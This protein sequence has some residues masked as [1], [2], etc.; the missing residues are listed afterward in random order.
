MNGIGTLRED[1]LHAALKAWYAQPGDRFESQVDGYVIDLVRDELLIEIQ[2]GNFSA[3]KPKLRTLL[4]SHP[5]RLVH[6]IA[7]E[8]WVVRVSTEGE[9]LGRRKSPKHGQLRDV[10]GELVHL[11]ALMRHA[12]L[13]VEVLLTHEEVIWREDGLGSWRR[14]GVSIAD[15][16]LL[17]VV[18]RHVFDE[19]DDFRALLPD[20]LPPVFT[21]PELSACTGQRR[22]SAQRMAYCLRVMGVTEVV[23]KRG[24]A[25][26]YQVTPSGSGQPPAG[27]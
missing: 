26:T 2:T 23:G 14:K 17:E 12:N 6:P 27:K 5:V 9:A 22:R 20:D 16:R 1:S 8:K 25:P 10:F 4:E 3:I 19:P 21:V 7:G 18:S 13:S 24:R 15:R 11:A